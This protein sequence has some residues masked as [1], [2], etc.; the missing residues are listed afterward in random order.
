MTETKNKPQQSSLQ[1]KWIGFLVLGF[2]ALCLG[3]VGFIIYQSS[4]STQ[5]QPVM[6]TERTQN[7]Q[8]D[9]DQRRADLNRSLS[10]MGSTRSQTQ[11][12]QSANQDFDFSQIIGAWEAT[13][14]DHLV[15]ILQ[16]TN[17]GYR[18]I[19]SKD[20]PR[21]NRFFSTGTYQLVEN[22]VLILNPDLSATAPQD[23]F[24][25][26][27]LHNSPFS[28]KLEQRAEFMI[29]SKPSSS[30]SFVSN[31]GAHPILRLTDD[32]LIIWN[33]F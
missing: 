11:N 8:S 31:P 16:I 21:A 27:R 29:W 30:N 18:L 28:V 4:V 26:R 20:N 33:P 12:A 24:R 15:G 10:E 1:S 6:Q 2:G 32:G 17:D 25:Y 14:S 23:G 7:A 19:L 5:S 3:A 13:L 22:N 9:T